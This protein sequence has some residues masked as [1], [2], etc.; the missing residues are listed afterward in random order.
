[1]CHVILAVLGLF[2]YPHNQFTYLPHCNCYQEIGPY[3]GDHIERIAG[4]YWPGYFK[5]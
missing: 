3:E 1:M 2:L 5:G 4:Y